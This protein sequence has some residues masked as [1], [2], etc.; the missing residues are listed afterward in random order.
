MQKK[1]F[2]AEYPVDRCQI[3][4]RVEKEVP[5]IFISVSLL[6]LLLPARTNGKIRK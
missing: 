6:S 5:F 3:L 2:S 4:F 1:C